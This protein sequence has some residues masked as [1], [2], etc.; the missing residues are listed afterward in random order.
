[1]LE[2]NLTPHGAA[3]RLRK[4]GFAALT[5]AATATAPAAAQAPASAAP[6]PAMKASMT[7]H[8]L[9]GSKLRVKG[10]L[11]A[12]AG[13]PITVQKAKG[14]HWSTVARTKTGRR[15]HFA[16]SF[17]PHSLGGVRVRVVGP[18]GAVRH[19]KA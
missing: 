15:G 16:T 8:A 18:N 2:V 12:P 17:R 11:F 3:A 14:G 1:M 5:I 9:V 10:A 7:N 19:L 13:S 6:A 4:P